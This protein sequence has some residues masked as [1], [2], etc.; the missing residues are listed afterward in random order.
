MYV[1]F[2]LG[3]EPQTLS[4]DLEPVILSS[5][6]H[7]PNVLSTIGAQEQPHQQEDKQIKRVLHGLMI[8]GLR[9]DI[10]CSA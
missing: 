3:I 9:K 8:P 5:L 2:V 10:Q 7:A 6:P 4:F 1:R